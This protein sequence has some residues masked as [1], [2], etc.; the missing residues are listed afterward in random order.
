[1][2]RNRIKR[3]RD[4]ALYYRTT[5]VANV[6]GI[7]PRTLLRKL[8][9]G[10]FPEPKRDQTNNYRIWTINDIEQLRTLMKG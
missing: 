1:M 5:E 7:S 10:E 2:P 4:R 6:L 3:N 9:S 8:K